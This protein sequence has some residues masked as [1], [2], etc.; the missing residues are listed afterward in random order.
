MAKS[1]ENYTSMIYYACKIK[2]Y[3]RWWNCTWDAMLVFVYVLY[4]WLL[5][6]YTADHW[7]RLIVTSLSGP[8]NWE[9]AKTNFAC[10]LLSRLPY[11]LR[12]WNRLHRN[13]SLLAASEPEK[14]GLKSEHDTSTFPIMRLICLPKFCITFVFHFFWVLQPSQEKLKAMLM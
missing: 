9:R 2:Y 12:A 11:Y 4:V 6:K 5:K 3:F 13:S 10:L 14:R 8:L 1:V 7:G